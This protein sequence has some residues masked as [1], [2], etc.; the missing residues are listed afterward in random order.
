MDTETMVKTAAFLFGLAALG[1]L[2]MAVMR[3]KGRP[4]PPDWLAMAHGLLAAAGLTLLIFGAFT[5]GVPYIAQ[6]SIGMFILAAA[7]GAVVN[8]LYHARQLPLP[9][10]LM[11]LHAL[12]A[13]AA[14][15]L[16]LMGIFR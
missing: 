3:L 2:T 6:V 5:F 16:L 9:I 12:L 11:S 14:F 8:L 1:G 15:A 13:V 4:R 7:G 10:P